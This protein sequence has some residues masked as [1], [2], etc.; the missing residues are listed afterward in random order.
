MPGTV[1]SALQ[2]LTDLRF[3]ATL[4]GWHYYDHPHFIDEEP[5]L[6]GGALDGKWQG[7]TRLSPGS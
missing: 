2:I 3:I 1:Q 4:R 5:E 7:Q 6:Q